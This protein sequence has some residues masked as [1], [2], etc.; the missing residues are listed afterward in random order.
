MWQPSKAEIR[1]SDIARRE[2]DRLA[3]RIPW[4]RLLEAR[5]LYVEWNAFSLWVRAIT[6]A[7]GE[8]PT[9]LSRILGERCPG[10]LECERQYREAYPEEESILWRRLAEWIEANVVGFAKHE[11]WLRAVTFYAVRDPAFSRDCAY[12][13]HSEKQW[14]RRRPSSYPS[15][16]EWRRASEVCSDDIID[17][18]EM[19]EDKRQIIKQCRKVTPECLAE[20][21]IQ[22]S[23][24][25]ALTYW[26]RSLLETD[27]EFPVVV[28]QELK[29]RAPDFLV[30][31]KELRCTLA[32]EHYSQRWKA[33]L[34]WGSDHLFT[35]AR[36]E[37]WF[38][39]LVY[40]SQAHP[41][42][43]RTIDYWVF[44]W[45]EHWSRLPLASYPSFREWRHAA[46]GFV[47]ESADE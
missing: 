8:I 1:L 19:R 42:S 20:A 40:C 28:T 41:R 34:K 38:D 15:F 18:F 45:D 16:E 2:A 30:S 36:Q 9:W 21:V 29:S 26:L 44:Y 4:Q 12:W 32:Q 33:L 31:D 10:F 47:V 46:D 3:R 27:T 5:R 22:Y 25:E 6:E 37:G 39:A 35:D 14:K 43:V 11:G 23:E 17:A 7:E 24:W 13:Q